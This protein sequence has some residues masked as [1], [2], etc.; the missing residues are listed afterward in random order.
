MAA[1]RRSHVRFSPS[2]P[3]P[4]NRGG[5]DVLT[6]CRRSFASARTPTHEGNETSSKGSSDNKRIWLRWD[7]P[8]GADAIF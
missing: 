8:S 1:G 2:S 6:L 3:V 5:I 4:R 7:S